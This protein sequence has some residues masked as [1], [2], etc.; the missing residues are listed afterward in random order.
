MRHR[1]AT[2]ALTGAFTGAIALLGVG[3]MAQV[4]AERQLDAALERL[5]L[6]FGA[7]AQLAVGMRQVDPVT[8]RA[9]LGDLTITSPRERLSVTE[10][11]V[12]E[13]TETRLGRA[14]ARSLVLL[15]NIGTDE[16]RFELARL[17][18]GGMALPAPG[19]GFTLE[20]FALGTL[21]LEAL[22]GSGKGG[23]LSVGRA[24]A[25]GYG[26][27]VL[28]AATLEGVDFRDDGKAGTSFRLGRVAVQSMV[29]PPLDG[30][31]PDPRLFSVQNLTLEGATLR[32]PEK[33]VDLAVGRFAVRDWVPGRTT[34][35]ALEG[36]RLATPFGQLGAGDLRI[37]R[38]AAQGIDIATTIAAVM[39]NKQVPD[40][41]PGTP[42]SIVMEGVAAEAGGRPMFSLGRLLVEASMD[43]SGLGS[44]NMALEGLRIS[45][46]PGASPWL[47]QAGYRD[48]SGGMELRGTVRREDGAVDVD[49]FR[50]AWDQAITTTLR[51]DL[52][53]MPLPRPG[54][55]RDNDAY[56]AQLMQARL[57]G[58]SLTL[59][60]Q[61]LL[62]RAIAQQARQQR[63]PEERLREQMAQAALAMP[64]PGAPPPGRPAAPAPARKS[65]PAAAPA[66]P[67]AD[68]FL[69]VRQA[70]A[71][72][73]RQ[74]G[75]LEFTLRPAQ[76]ISLGELQSLTDGGPA[77]TARRLGLTA[78]AR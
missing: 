16:D 38:V 24:S 40:P 48:L 10:L 71:S 43:T 8:G 54:E 18:L 7:D 57:R 33:Q 30:S 39:D 69:P 63:I 13:V 65:A 15:T 5:R 12:Q 3:A 19:T 29:L 49:P 4:E 70:I 27:G 9:R 1:L 23:N 32:D 78:V 74:P 58:M 77:E 44:S 73:I 62:G 51:A 50:I 68:P 59:R 21:E 45:L 72:F 64:I 53:G 41:V 26:P 11:L 46:P 55:A 34:D 6:A 17:V 25:E 52:I 22:R 61:G 66:A 76:P 42:Q 20:T 14:E 47:D 56:M 35:V 2:L 67:A 28:G 36:V 75:E 60:D 31:T 37:G